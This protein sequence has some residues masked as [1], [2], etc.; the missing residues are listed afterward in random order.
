MPKRYIAQPRLI[1]V[2]ENFPED[3]QRIV[4]KMSCKSL[5]RIAV[6]SLSP[7]MKYHAC[8]RCLVCAA[9]AEITERA[10]A[11]QYEPEYVKS[12]IEG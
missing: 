12:L 7:R 3:L 5:Q 11:M 6:V 2:K 8:T 1:P 9:V 4:S 10:A